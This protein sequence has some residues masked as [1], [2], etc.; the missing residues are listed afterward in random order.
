VGGGS[1]Q[2]K[3]NSFCND[4]RLTG[5]PVGLVNFQGILSS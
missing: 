2:G 3:N 1:S 4:S 5:K